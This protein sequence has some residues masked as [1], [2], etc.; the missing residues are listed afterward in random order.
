MLTF[1]PKITN[2]DVELIKELCNEIMCGETKISLNDVAEK[3]EIS[4]KMVLEIWA[5]KPLRITQ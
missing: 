1:D 2:H 5:G 4:K 3:F